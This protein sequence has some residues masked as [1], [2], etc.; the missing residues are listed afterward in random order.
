MYGVTLRPTD[1]GLTVSARPT[2][3]GEADLQQQRSVSD[4]TPVALQESSSQVGAM[5]KRK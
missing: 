4:L 2:D 5:D 1:P 3:R